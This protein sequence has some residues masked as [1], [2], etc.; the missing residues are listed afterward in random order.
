M[1][2]SLDGFAPGRQGMHN[3]RPVE[4]EARFRVSLNWEAT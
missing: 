3:I 4:Q 2:A 1:I